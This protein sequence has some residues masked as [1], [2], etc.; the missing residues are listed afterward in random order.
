MSEAKKSY[1][2]FCKSGQESRV[3]NKLRARGYD[4]LAPFVIRWKPS[5]Q[6]IKRSACRLLPGYVFFETADIPD[7]SQLISDEEVLRIL[8]YEDGQYAL[9][10]SDL[11]FVAWLKKY[12]G[13]I[14]ISHVLQVGSKVEFLDGPLKDMAGHVTKDNK[15]RKQVQIVLGDEG[16]LLHSIW[17]SIEYVEANADTE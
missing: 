5:A 4:P 17:C 11:A 10:G 6:G 8:Q 3:M 14:E 1:C 12:D 9:R 13:T 15:N 2:L 7:W 16:T